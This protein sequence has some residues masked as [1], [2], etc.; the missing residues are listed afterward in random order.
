M[1]GEVDDESKIFSKMEKEESELELVKFEGS[2]AGI[3][4]PDPHKIIIPVGSSEDWTDLI[5]EYSEKD[6]FLLG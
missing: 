2:P 6:C 1:Q 4:R 3:K 5:K